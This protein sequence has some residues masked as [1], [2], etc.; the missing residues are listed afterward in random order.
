MQGLYA[1][2]YVVFTFVYS[3]EIGVNLKNV[4]IPKIDFVSS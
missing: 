3:K 1:I 4:Q 2:Q